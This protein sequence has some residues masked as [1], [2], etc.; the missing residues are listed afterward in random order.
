MEKG[1][2]RQRETRT[3]V[4]GARE[5]QRGKIRMSDIGDCI[6]TGVEDSEKGDRYFSGESGASGGT[7]RDHDFPLRERVEKAIAPYRLSHFERLADFRERFGRKG[8]ES[9]PETRN[10]R[11]SGRFGTPRVS[12]TRVISD[13]L[14]SR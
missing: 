12:P 1:Q 4:L 9:R 11:V 14:T 2:N 5:P 7:G 3:I 10:A 13:C 8:R 6:R